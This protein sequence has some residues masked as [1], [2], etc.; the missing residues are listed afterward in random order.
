[1]SVKIGSGRIYQELLLPTMV[2]NFHSLKNTWDT[3]PHCTA[4]AGHTRDPSAVCLG[5][6]VSGRTKGTK[7]QE[8]KRGKRWEARGTHIIGNGSSFHDTTS[9]PKSWFP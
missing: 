6:G 1:M 3:G 2:H 8:R 4:A 9:L 7:G 5:C